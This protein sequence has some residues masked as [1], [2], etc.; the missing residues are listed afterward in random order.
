LADHSDMAALILLLLLLLLLLL[1]LLVD[2]SMSG[3]RMNSPSFFKQCVRMMQRSAVPGAATC[4][5]ST[6]LHNALPY[7]AELRAPVTATLADV[8][9]SNSPPCQ[10]DPFAAAVSDSLK[11]SVWNRAVQQLEK[12][13]EMTCT[14]S[15]DAVGCWAALE[16]RCREETFCSSATCSCRAAALAAS[17]C[18]CSPN[19]TFW[20]SKLA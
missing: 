12:A 17:A 4:K 11:C 10:C 18:C 19:D 3:G 20:A 14:S 6:K 1:P 13:S 15:S 9:G 7:C 5:C 2:F 16:G 8:R